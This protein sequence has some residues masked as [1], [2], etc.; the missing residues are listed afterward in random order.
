MNDVQT[1]QLNRAQK[2]AQF[3][4]DHAAELEATPDILKEVSQHKKSQ[5]I[6]GFAAETENVLENARQKLVA[7]NLDAIVVN[8]QN[9][10][11]QQV[12]LTEKKWTT[13]QPLLKLQTEVPL[14]KSA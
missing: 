11:A 8:A 14:A 3:L 5:I 4:N 13:R 6:V 2:D 12:V 10:L 1:N 7:K 9:R